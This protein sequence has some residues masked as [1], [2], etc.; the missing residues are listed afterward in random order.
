MTITWRS[1]QKHQRRLMI[2]NAILLHWLDKCFRN[3]F[4][5]S[6]SKFSIPHLKTKITQK[7]L[8]QHSNYTLCLFIEFRCFDACL[9]RLVVQC[10]EYLLHIKSNG[11][12]IKGSVVTFTADLLETNGSL[13]DVGDT[14]KWVRIK[15]MFNFFASPFMKIHFYIWKPPNETYTAHSPMLIFHIQN[16]F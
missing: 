4:I 1:M 6:N 15:S 13:A 2:Q 12:A 16:L 5:C 7:H 10:R 8:A 11:P 3:H 14:L 9:K